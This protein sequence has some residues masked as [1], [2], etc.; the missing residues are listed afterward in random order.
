[1]AITYKPLL[2]LLV[3]RGMKKMD[4]RTELSLGPSTIAKFDKGEYVS[5]EVIEK[6]CAFFDVQ[7][8]DI[9]EY[10]KEQEG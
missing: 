7:P 2:K 8:N 1:M 5:L 9:I 3:E 6:L 4:L 10:V